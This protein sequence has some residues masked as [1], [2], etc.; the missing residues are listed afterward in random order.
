MFDRSSS[1]SG[2]KRSPA[3][4][5]LNAGQSPDATVAAGMARLEVTGDACPHAVN[6]NAEIARECFVMWEGDVVK[7]RCSSPTG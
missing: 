3:S 4:V 5:R 2:E 6:A 1:A 7:V